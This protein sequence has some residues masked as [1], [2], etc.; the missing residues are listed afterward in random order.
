[1]IMTAALSV[2]LAAVLIGER[3]VRVGI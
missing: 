3:M 2:Y 1:V